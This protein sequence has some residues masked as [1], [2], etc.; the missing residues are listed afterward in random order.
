MEKYVKL[1]MISVLA[2]A[3][4]LFLAFG[5]ADTN[6]KTADSG[7]SSSGGGSSKASEPAPISVSASTLFSDYDA[8]EVAADE[9]YKDK[10]LLVNGTVDD[11]KKDI[12][13]TM[14]VT[15]KTSNPILSV[16][17]YFDD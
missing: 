9:K 17:C 8:N 6:K 5:S 1:N 2:L 10:I 14:Y 16:Q 13:D 11:I 15:L 4:F 12:M 7:G 3:G